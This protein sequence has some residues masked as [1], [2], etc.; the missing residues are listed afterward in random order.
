MPLPSRLALFGL[1]CLSA[2]ERN[3]IEPIDRPRPVPPSSTEIRE[4][5]GPATVSLRPESLPYLVIQ[6][7]QPE[8]FDASISAPAKVDFRTK[9]VSA[10]GTIVPGRVTQVHAQIGERIRAGAPLATLVS[11]D[12]AQMRSDF[13]RAEAE[14]R[15][16]EDRRRRQAEMAR[17]GVG[18]EVERM[19]AETEYRQALTEYERSRDL[20]QLIGDGRGGEVVVRAPMDS[21]VLKAHVSVGAAVGPG[22]PLFDLGEP[23][24]AWIVA[25][26][27]ENDL[28]LVEVGAKASIELA[29]LPNAISGHVVGESAAIQNE[30][31]RAS[32]FIEPDDPAVPLRPGMYARV[33]IAVSKSG[34]IVLPT[35]AVLIKD[36]RET[37]VYVEQEPGIFEARPVR[38]GQ[39]RAGMTPILEG[40]SG[41]ERVVVKG[42]LLLDGEAAMLL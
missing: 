14:L 11:A 34:R 37:F 5:H 25:D 8:A 19:E 12:A 10:A 15:R 23:S 36:G 40:L 28:L 2:C 35:S 6:E 1:L 13:S 41:G 17:R 21:V 29:S 33:S 31:R 3:G 20:L 24:A 27:F 22:S 42:A 4:G 38:V 9:A 30:L 18:L 16:A 7:I 26:V 32:V 39:S